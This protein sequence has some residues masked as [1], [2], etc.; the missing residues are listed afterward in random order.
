MQGWVYAEGQWRAIEA[1]TIPDALAN[2]GSF[3]WMELQDVSTQE[4]NRLGNLFKLHELAIEDVIAARQR[5]KIEEYPN[6]ELFL[7]MRTAMEWNGHIEYGETHLFLG[8][9]HILIVRHGPG[10][11]YDH[12]LRRLKQGRFTP[13][14][15]A[16]LYA[17]LDQAV[18]AYRPVAD[19]LV[20]RYDSYESALLESELADKNLTR[21]YRLKRQTLQLT[22]SVEPMEDMVQEL[23]RM[24]PEI[25][26]KGLK[27]YYRDVQDHLARLNRD[28]FQM[29]EMLTDAM[30]ISLAS[31]S[32]RQNDSVQKL[33]GWG[34]ILAIPTLVFSLYGM[35]FKFMP[36]LD[37]RWGYP[38]TLSLTGAACYG[39]YRHL[40]ERGWI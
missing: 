11:G 40:K 22:Q 27:A 15:G 29:R 18:D 37:W 7:V 24:H 31:L 39:L 30:N 6:G 21:L 13:S 20:E 9:R 34:A 14:V 5:P 17:V 26:E 2:P 23:I 3:V 10:P 8:Q 33:A 35:N 36:E 38:L 12:A 16:A 1:E 4:L 32:L 28:L 19:R 25:V